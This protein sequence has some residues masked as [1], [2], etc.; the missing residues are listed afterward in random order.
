[1]AINKKKKI[2]KLG[3]EAKLEVLGDFQ[4]QGHLL[5]KGYLYN[6]CK[7]FS[8][9]WWGFLELEIKTEDKAF[10]KNFCPV[11]SISYLLGEGGSSGFLETGITNIRM[12]PNF[13][14]NRDNTS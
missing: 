3:T 11:I 14:S 12:S 8:K 2:Q 13:N 6:D 5:T 4:K 10:M 1:M 7:P 9:Q